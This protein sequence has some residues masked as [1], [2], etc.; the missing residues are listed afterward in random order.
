MLA[1][2]CVLAACGTETSEELPYEPLG[3]SG[4]RV[5]ERAQAGLDETSVPARGRVVPSDDQSARPPWVSG[6]GG[7][8]GAGRFPDRQGRPMMTDEEAA[9]ASREIVQAP[10]EGDGPCAQAYSALAQLSGSFQEKTPW[11]PRSRPDRGGFMEGCLSLP[12]EA[13]RCLV[14]QYRAAHEA[15]CNQALG[16]ATP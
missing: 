1:I 13:Q 16:T 15:D 10:P 8:G 9:A 6:R 12:P 14:P 11:V 4:A 7:G 2:A 3:S 5:E